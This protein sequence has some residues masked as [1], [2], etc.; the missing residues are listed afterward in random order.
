MVRWV[1][2]SGV[3]G[4]SG[5]CE[6]GTDRAETTGDTAEAS[7]VPTSDSERPESPLAA[8]PCP[9]ALA[10]GEALL[11]TLPSAG[12]ATR[13]G[14]RA[15]EADPWAYT[16]DL[17]RVGDL[18]VA[19]RVPDG[20]DPGLYQ[21]VV[22]RGEEALAEAQIEVLDAPPAGPPTPSSIVEVASPTGKYLGPPRINPYPAP[23]LTANP[24]VV[25]TYG[26]FPASDAECDPDSD[27]TRSASGELVVREFVRDI[28]T[29]ESVQNDGFGTF[30]FVAHTV[31]FTIQ[32]PEGSET[33][34]GRVGNLRVAPYN[35]LAFVVDV[36]VRS[37]TTCRQL[38]FISEVECASP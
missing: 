38:T 32:R 12:E 16:D 18:G 11:L 36:V 6:G 35:P 17:Q 4:G 9:S 15:S 37:T 2:V 8:V 19:I 21:V 33:Y 27:P 7:V 25:Y 30:D 20:Q 3:V 28:Q 31:S 24:D 1:L 29:D 10:T 13:V 22:F 23:G 26:M 14:L 34:E 5:G